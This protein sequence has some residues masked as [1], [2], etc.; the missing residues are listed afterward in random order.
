MGFTLAGC[1]SDDPP[2]APPPPTVDVARPEIREVTQYFN[3]TGTLESTASVEIR[4]RVDGFLEAVIFEE[5]TE[6][7]AGD[8]LFRIEQEP[9]E[10][11]VARAEAT[12]ERAQAVQALA[13][14][15]LARTR[16]AFE[17]EAAN[18]IELIEDEAEVQQARAEVLAAEAD[19]E[20][21]RLDLSY[22]DVVAPISGRIDRNY[23]DVGNLVGRESAT[24]LARIDVLDPLYVTFDVSE[25]I[26]LK[27][28]TVGHNRPEEAGFPAVE[29]A[30]ADEEGFP[31]R[32]RVDF[33]ENAVDGDTGTLLVRAKLDNPTGKLYPGLF[34]RIRVP[35]ET[36][37]NAVLIDEQAVSTGLQGKT[38]LVLDDQNTVSRRQVTLGARQDDGTIIVLEGMDGT[39]RYI[40]QG[41][42]KARPGEPVRAREI[43]TSPTETNPAETSSV[44][45]G[46]TP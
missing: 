35:W 8:A 39:E 20:S 9:Y 12:L 32:G 14:T 6:V 18:E 45:T 10:I 28:L 40:V 13:E 37:Q 38:V 23:V 26:V 30:L 3:Y 46:T 5:S 4:A 31:H 16:D 15:R 1:E 36:R 21:A 19:L 7:Q 44:N 41:I 17:A 29:V 43:E 22:T 33:N 42:Q 25:S 27:Y 34:A 2:P 11:A 24:L